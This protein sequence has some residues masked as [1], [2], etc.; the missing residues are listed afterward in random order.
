MR[1]CGLAGLAL[2][3]LLGGGVR[4]DEKKADKAE[5]VREEGKRLNGTWEVVSAVFDG[6]KQPVPRKA[7]LTIKGD[8]YTVREGEKVV[9]DGTF[10]VDPT[11]TPKSLD[12]IPSS[13]PDK[14]KPHRGIYEV[15]GDTYRVCLAPPGK[16]RP[17]AFESKE[18]S[19]HALVTYKRAKPKD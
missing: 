16:P 3:L 18:G 8:K 9:A 7:T 2:A 14:G 4:A 5:A 15:K 6:T 10:T 1:R 19:G 17:K 11:A 13:G 12:G